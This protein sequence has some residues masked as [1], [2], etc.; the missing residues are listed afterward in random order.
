MPEIINSVKTGKVGVFDIGKKWIDI[1]NIYD[2]K[3]A[4]KEI[5]FW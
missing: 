3:K 2:F 1:G 4:S 5:Q